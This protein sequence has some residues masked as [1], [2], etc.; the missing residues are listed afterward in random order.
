MERHR[1]ARDLLESSLEERLRILGPDSPDTL[2]SRHALA[3]ATAA[4][5]RYDEA[6][7]RHEENLEA[8]LRLRGPDDQHTRDTIDALEQARANA[9]PD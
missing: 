2:L 4:L 9:A 3:R 1:E 5:G 7:A 8:W 6:I